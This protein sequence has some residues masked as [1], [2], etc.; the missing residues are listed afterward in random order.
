MRHSRILIAIALIFLVVPLRAET[1]SLESTP[2]KY[3][4]DLGTMETPW[5]I[6][7]V[8]DRLRPTHTPPPKYPPEARRAHVEGEVIAAVLVDERGVVRDAQ[9]Q[10][11]S[12][13]ISLDQAAI[14]AIRKWKYERR[15][16]A[17]RY[18][19]VQPVVFSL[20]DS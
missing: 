16:K 17:G 10:R 3:E 12:G 1:K 13:N 20:V 2:K 7:Q 5:G 11:S 8:Y 6:L 18:V 15:Q 14:S 19:T 4:A 9:V